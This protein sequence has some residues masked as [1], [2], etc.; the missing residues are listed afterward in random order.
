MMWVEWIFLI[1]CSQQNKQTP[2]LSNKAFWDRRASVL[3]LAFSPNFLL[4]S[5]LMILWNHRKEYNSLNQHNLYE[6]GQCSHQTYCQWEIFAVSQIDCFI[7]NGVVEYNENCC[8]ARNLDSLHLYTLI[9]LFSLLFL[10]FQLGS[11]LR[12]VVWFLVWTFQFVT[13]LNIRR[14]TLFSSSEVSFVNMLSFWKIE[15]WYLWMS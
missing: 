7:A 6:G 5:L 2:S 15:I 9:L 13:R 8:Q 14:H 1:M 12:E 10:Q 3:H 11:V 4:S